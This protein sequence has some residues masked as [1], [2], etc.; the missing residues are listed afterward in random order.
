MGKVKIGPHWFDVEMVEVVNKNVPRY[1]QMNS[2]EGRILID[3]EIPKSRQEE[4]L[5]HEVL[6][7]LDYSLEDCKLSEETV[8][9]LAYGFYMFLVDNKLLNHEALNKILDKEKG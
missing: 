3:I 4:V 1:G 8:G 9:R 6:H 5:L 2:T 7:E